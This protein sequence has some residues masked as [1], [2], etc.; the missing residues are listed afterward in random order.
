VLS[1]DKVRKFKTA[2]EVY[3]LG[4]DAFDRPRTACLRFVKRLDAV[5]RPWFGYR[6]FG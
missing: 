2:P 1:A 5:V 4:V 3:Q 6:S